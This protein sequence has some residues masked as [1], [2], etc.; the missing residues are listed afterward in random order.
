MHHT[1]QAAAE[2]M[3]AIDRQIKQIDNY[4]SNTP[5]T[6]AQ[7]KNAAFRRKIFA[8]LLASATN[9]YNACQQ[10]ENENKAITQARQFDKKINVLKDTAPSAAGFA[11]W[12]ATYY[13]S[14]QKKIMDLN[15]FGML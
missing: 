13:A 5:L 6:D 4:I 12:K 9:V 15:K 8:D 14:K 2:H 11:A 3:A 7:R 1:T 10:L